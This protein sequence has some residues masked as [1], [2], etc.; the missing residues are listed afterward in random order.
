MP[1]G[2]QE[3]YRVDCPNSS[4]IPTNPPGSRIS[5][6]PY[7]TRFP[8]RPAHSARLPYSTYPAPPT[9]KTMPSENAMRLPRPLVAPLTPDP[10]GPPPTP[11]PTFTFRGARGSR[12]KYS[13]VTC[14][15]WLEADEESISASVKRV[16]ASSLFVG[17]KFLTPEMRFSKPP[18]FKR[19]V[20]YRGVSWLR[21]RPNGRACTHPVTKRTETFE[22][23][24]SLA[25]TTQYWRRTSPDSGGGSHLSYFSRPPHVFKRSDVGTRRLELLL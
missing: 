15:D 17:R 19:S 5:V 6:P 7:V 12:N 2:S 25:T 16:T 9:T 18:S 11:R 20:S 4:R 24:A 22:Q 14:N 21:T 3:S 10:L 13:S 1:P 8:V 23:F